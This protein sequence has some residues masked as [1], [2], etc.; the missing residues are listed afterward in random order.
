MLAS[1]VSCGH[2]HSKRNDAILC[3][4][5]QGCCQ[6]SKGEGA[7]EA[8]AAAPEGCRVLPA[9]RLATGAADPFARRATGT[10]HSIDCRLAIRVGT[11]TGRHSRLLFALQPLLSIFL[12][13][14]AATSM[15]SAC[16]SAPAQCGASSAGHSEAM[17]ACADYKL[18]Q[19]RTCLQA[20]P[21]ISCTVKASEHG[22]ILYEM[23]GDT[24]MQVLH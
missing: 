24:C 18:W 22:L 6:H 23:F 19:C 4:C 5:S 16:S 3:A 13:R 21:D 1:L 12:A 17:L 15:C 2:Q 9:P 20:S 8:A 14:C 10:V 7:Q 11:L